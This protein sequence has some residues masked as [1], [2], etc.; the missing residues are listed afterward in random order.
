MDEIRVEVTDGPFA[1]LPAVLVSHTGDRVQVRVSIF[2][3]ETPVELQSTQVRGAD[4]GYRHPVDATRPSHEALRERIVAQFEQLAAVETFAFFLDRVDEPETDL[5]GEWDA[6]LAHRDA[7]DARTRRRLQAALERFDRQLA[8][9][10]ADEAEHLIAGDAEF[11]HPGTA[12]TREQRG[13]EPDAEQRLRAAI[14][15]EPVAETVVPPRERAGHRREQARLA[16]EERDYELWKASLSPDQR[17]LF[18]SRGNPARY[19]YA[20]AP[21][22]DVSMPPERTVEWAIRSRTGVGEGAIPQEALDAVDGLTLTLHRP[23]DLTM[24]GHLHNLRWLSVRSSVQVDLAALVSALLAARSL[25]DLSIEAPVRDIAA[26]ARLTGL[27]SLQLQHTQ[28]TDLAPLAGLTRLSD[29]SVC[30]GPL[31]DLTPLSRLGLARLF[32]YRTRVRD[33]RPLAGMATLEVLGLAGCPVQDLE[34]IAAL[35][36][37]RFVSLHGTPVSDLGDLPGRAPGVVFEG[38]GEQQPGSAAAPYVGPRA[39]APASDDAAAELRAA[40]AAAGDDHVRRGQV[41]RAMLAGRRLDLVEEIV[42]GH[43]GSRHAAVAGLLV[44]GGVGDVGFPDTPWGIASGA[45]LTE[46]L[47]QVWAPVAAFAP[48]FVGAVHDRTLG[49][50]LLIDAD[51][52]P[53]LGYLVWRHNGSE[54]LGDA[55]DAL[56]RFADPARDFHLSLVVGSA[57]RVADPAV[58]VP[59]LAGPVPRPVRDFWAVHYRLD[60][61][62]E[63]VG[64]GL[65]CNTLEFHDGDGWSVVSARL[66]GLPP[67]RFV[68]AAGN[69]NYDIYVLDLDMLDSG[70]NP[71]VAHWA[72][73]EWQLDDHQQYWEWLDSAATDLVFGT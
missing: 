9:L 25:R 19:A 65:D 2:G 14:F 62:W 60:N 16:A 31:S 50:V 35:P 8:P 73:K 48:R 67:D 10:P 15:G 43:C 36:G 22:H 39:A 47:D 55:P 70:G 49:L 30:D 26:L 38:V 28:V 52:A 6:Y 68:H 7:T 54:R 1:G 63:S 57:P 61:G 5:A 42:G 18:P 45:G 24:L 32:V 59:V 3:R 53:A 44:R 72:F 64:G 11:W 17:Q 58:V 34:A 66:G 23:A 69:A 51:G 40:F 13:R 56:D 21:R 33:L 12:A 71:T 29:L 4:G 27:R 46:A 20:R 41:E 37:L